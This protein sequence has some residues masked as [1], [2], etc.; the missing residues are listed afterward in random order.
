MKTYIADLVVRDPN[1][2]FIALIEVKNWQNPNFEMAVAQLNAIIATET[3]PY[4]Q[5]FLILSQEK[6][7]LWKNPNGKKIK[8]SPDV[9]F[10]MTNVIN[11][12]VA[13]QNKGTWLKDYQLE[14]LLLRWLIELSWLKQVPNEEP[15]NLPA[16]A[17]F[18]IPIR[19]TS[20]LQESRLSL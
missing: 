6:R 10:S 15:E 18:V 7:F 3:I 13:E 4:A 2:Q 17:D 11:R 16:L 8:Q 12:Y 14:S 5:F 19:D 20:V 1:G 9:E